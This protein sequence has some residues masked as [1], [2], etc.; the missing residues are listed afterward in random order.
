MRIE[1]DDRL[2]ERA[3]E[4]LHD[5]DDRRDAAEM[6]IEEL[7][8]DADYDDTPPHGSDSRVTTTT[9]LVLGAIAAALVVGL[10]FLWSL[11]W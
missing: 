10:V 1:D 11:C 3:I 2:T 4:Q 7:V 5:L 9:L 6:R 8:R